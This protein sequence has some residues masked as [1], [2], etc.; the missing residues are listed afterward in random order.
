[1][2]QFSDSSPEAGID[3]RQAPCYGEVL[4]I[5]A[6]APASDKEQSPMLRT[7]H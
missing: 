3:C 1:M 5:P 2:W 7:L 4:F 6:E